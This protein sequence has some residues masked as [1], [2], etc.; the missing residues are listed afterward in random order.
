MKKMTCQPIRLRVFSVACLRRTAFLTAFC[1]LWSCLS[2][3]LAGAAANPKGSRSASTVPLASALAA[4]R[5]GTSWPGQSGHFLGRLSGRQPSYASLTAALPASP[6]PPSLLD[7]VGLQARPVSESQVYSWKTE[8]KQSGIKQARIRT[9]GTEQAETDGSRAAWLH[10]WLGEYEMA[11]NQHPRLARWHFRVAASLGRSSLRQAS[12]LHQSLSPDGRASSPLSRATGHDRDLPQATPGSSCL[13]LA[14]YDTALALFYEGAYRDAGEAFRH[15]IAVHTP[16]SGYDPSRCALWLR[17]ANACAG[18]HAER[19]DLGIPEPPRLDP[20]CG[21][22]ALAACL[23]SLG[24]PYDQRTV[25]AACRVTGE[26]ST[27]QDVVQ[28]GP[29]LGVSIR[30]VS[31]DERGFLALPKPLVAHVEHDHFLVVV[32]ADRK[33]VTYLCSDCGPWPGGRVTLTWKQWRALSPGIYAAVTRPQSPWSATLAAALHETSP[34]L[35]LTPVRVAS[36]GL[37]SGLGLSARPATV[38]PLRYVLPLLRGH[39]VRE[40]ATATY[41]CGARPSGLRPPGNSNPPMDG[42]PINLATGEEQQTPSADLV[43]YNPHGPAVSWGRIYNSLRNE[44]QGNLEGDNTYESND[45]GMGWSQAYNAGVYDPTNGAAGSSP[46][47]VFFPNG[48]RDSFTAPAAPTSAAPVQC[49][50]Q[51]GT[52]LAVEWDYDAQSASGHY[53]ITLPDRTRLVTT[54]L[55]PATLC[56]SLSQIVDRGGNAINFNYGPAAS[57]GTWPLLSSI[58]DA[59]NGTVLLNIQ[60]AT[61]GTGNIVAVT[62]AYG[63]SVYYHVGIHASYSYLHPYCQ[64]LDQVSQIVPYGTA[65]P[66][67]RS[68]YG[69]QQVAGASSGFLFSFLN[70]ITEPSPAGTGASTRTINYSPGTGIVSGVT[71]ANG[72]TRGYDSVDVSGQ[73]SYPSDYTRV[74]IAGAGGSVAYSFIKGYDNNMNETSA[75]DGGGTV[76]S[77]LAYTDPYD[78][79]KPSSLTD[80]KGRVWSSHYDAYGNVTSSVSPRGVTITNTW[81]YSQF[82]LGELTETQVSS[83]SGTLAPTTFAYYEPSGLP[84]TITSPKPGTVG[85]TDTVTTTFTYDFTSQGDPG[86]G[87]VLTVTTPGNDAASAITTTFGYASDGSY[88]QSAALGQPL[89]VTDNLGKTSH[90]RY[91][92]M[93]R[94]VSAADAL[95]HEVDTQYNIA[96][97]VVQVTLPATGQTG[98]GRAYSVSGYLFPGGPLMGAAAYDENGVQVRQVSYGYDPVG[99]ALSVSGSAEPVTYAYDAL[100]R[101]TA[102]TDGNGHTTHYYYNKAGY[103][104][105]MTYPGYSG[106]TPAFDGNR[107]SNVAGPDSIRNSQYDTD[108][109]LLKSVDGRGTETDYAYTDPDGAL[110]DVQYPAASSLNHHVTYDAFGRAATMADGSGTVQFGTGST[111]G[112]DDLGHVLSVQTTYTGLLAKT[113]SYAYYPNG[114]RQSLDTP[115]GSFAYHYDGDGRLQNLTNPFAETTQW[116]YLDNGWLSTQTLGNGAAT[117]YTQNALGQL[118]DLT[119]RASNASVLSDFGGM[120]YDGAGNRTAV[121]AS[122][123]AVPSYGGLTSYQYDPK[124]QLTQEQSARGG[125]YTSGFGYD[126]AGN[127]TTSRSSGPNSF[128]ADNQVVA[129]GYG[130]D[131]NGNPTIYKGTA[132]TYDAEDHPTGFGSLMTAGYTGAGL[133]AWKGDGSGGSRT[134][135][136]YDGAA[137]VCELSSTGAV[138]ATNTFGGTG[139]LSRHTVS[140]STFYAFDERGN[141]AQRLDA[142]G[143]PTSSAMYDA[144]GASASAPPDPFGFGGQFGYYTDAETGLQLCSHRYYDSATGRFLTRDPLGY[145]GGLNLY[146]YCANNPVNSADPS[147]FNPQ[148]DGGDGGGNGGTSPDGLPRMWYDDLADN[149]Q[150]VYGPLIDGLHR[151]GF[152]SPLSNS[153]LGGADPSNIL[154]GINDLGHLPQNIGHLGEASATGGAGGVAKDLVT[155]ATVV[156]LAVGGANASGKESI[157]LFRAVKDD[158]LADIAATRRFSNPPGIQVKYFATSAEG[159]A[160]YAKQAYSLFGESEG[161][162]TIVRTVAPKSIAGYCPPVDGGISAVVVRSADLSAL[163]RA[164]ILPTSP[165]P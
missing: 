154:S 31:A 121:T 19:A 23:R 146:A 142:A 125:G 108:G 62:D 89:T 54:V 118:T 67:N 107:W 156:L 160:S 86:L 33:G 37:L 69:Y 8:I 135:F 18:Y 25:L 52:A 68:V 97:Q 12:S 13:G 59:G 102:L 38:R 91:D 10:L 77:M 115:A 14:E 123:P 44:G 120:A 22:A 133:R 80:A 29:R 56:C 129:T 145:A 42:D 163:G 153:L 2:V 124:D 90:L 157:T 106:P 70:T 71:D 63:R 159:A 122:L 24:L 4:V 132:L 127:P 161:G 165:I 155:A 76:V 51:A 83:S 112:Y 47:Y 5:K 113:L 109:H 81:D 139:L 50:V 126:A 79:F 15:L 85:S 55:N 164:R 64:Q 61:D 28:A 100:Y 26:G 20:L 140:G 111:P 65:S 137:P 105:A 49:T 141:V 73:P 6:A 66:A 82:A 21:A 136:L 43:V 94:A 7:E 32:S 144:Y 152:G 149:D 99:T 48:S 130:Y 92:A 40:Q 116:A 103:L 78:P 46:R 3:G 138:T 27:L 1:L 39:V 98:S 93:G 11:H 35:S 95:G 45:F 87:N 110:T 158:E 57:G 9:A 134:Y 131:G 30:A 58:S 117:I 162:Y 128:G 101:M 143:S 96:G 75:T 151:M 104:D 84:H 41:G 72:N 150:S 74:T 60:R 53:T 148:S 147:G 88:S 119:T 16:T 17:R 36:A 34:L 114:S